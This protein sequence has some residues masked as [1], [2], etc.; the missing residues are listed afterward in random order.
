MKILPAI[1][2]SYRRTRQSTITLG[3]HLPA[4]TEQYL[5][6]LD[7][8]LRGEIAFRRAGDFC[9][10][11]QAFRPDFATARAAAPRRGAINTRRWSTPALSQNDSAI[12]ARLLSQEGAMLRPKLPVL[13]RKE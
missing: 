10:P 3:T 6:K 7:A 5:Q 11:P 4:V 12:I 2:K 9:P 8:F 1:P 13:V